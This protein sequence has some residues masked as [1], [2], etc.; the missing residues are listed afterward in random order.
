MLI[1]QNIPVTS[2]S[3]RVLWIIFIICTLFSNE[4]KAQNYENYDD[5]YDYYGDYYYERPTGDSVECGGELVDDEGTITSPGYP[6]EA[7]PTGTY[8]SFTDCFW[9][10]NGVKTT[11]IQF[12]FWDMAVEI[13]EG[14]STVT[15]DFDRINVSVTS[16]GWKLFCGYETPSDELQ[17]T[18]S[19]SIHFRSDSSVNYRGFVATY[20]ITEDHN[21]C[22][23]SP[24]QYGECELNEA[25]TLPNCVCDA[26]WTGEQCTLD[27]SECWSEPCQNGGTCEENEPNRYDC[28][29]LP[30][31]TGIHCET[32]DDGSSATDERLSDDDSSNNNKPVSDD[33]DTKDDK[34]SNGKKPTSGKSTSRDSGKK[35]KENK[36]SSP[37]Q[38]S[39]CVNG[40]AC[41]EVKGD[42][43]TCRCQPNYEGENCE[44]E[45][46]CGDPGIPDLQKGKRF[47][48]GDTV[49]FYC[50]R[51]FIL[52]G[53]R[54]VSCFENGTW[55]LEVPKCLVNKTNEDQKESSEAWKTTMIG[56]GIA[57]GGNLII[58]GVWVANSGPLMKVGEVASFPN[59]ANNALPKRYDNISLNTINLSDDDISETDEDSSDDSDED[60]ITKPGRDTP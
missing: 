13:G 14:D 5:Y 54:N 40:G 26:G 15:C 47:T 43:Y 16:L 10:K 9:Y 21:P 36:P 17:G 33:K 11:L 24:C 59:N 32:R 44:I 2:T 31:W 12:K 51:G 1:T 35:E 42:N 41:I 60:Y 22:E 52:S 18:G 30:G 37:C 7:N 39:P 53:P 19:L 48:A 49:K 46:G 23:P 38:P 50:E 6:S 58:F 29:C 25:G 27:I 4:L 8:P 34:A 3:F 45:T 20:K 57:F 56:L 28:A 55:S